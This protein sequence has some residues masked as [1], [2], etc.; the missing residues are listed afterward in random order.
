MNKNGTQL[1]ARTDLKLCI[2][3]MIMMELCRIHL[4]ILRSGSYTDNLEND[5]FNLE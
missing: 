4:D 2:M 1:Y 5:K 3:F